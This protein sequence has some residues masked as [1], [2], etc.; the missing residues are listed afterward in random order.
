MARQVGGFGKM[1]RVWSRVYVFRPFPQKNLPRVWR[2][3]CVWRVYVFGISCL[4][5]MSHVFDVFD[6]FTCLGFFV[7]KKYGM[8]L[9]CLACLRVWEI[10]SSKIVACVWRVSGVGIFLVQIMSHVFDVIDVFGVFTCLDLSPKKWAMC[11]TCLR[12]W[13]FSLKILAM[14]LMCLRIWD[15]FSPKNEP[16]V[17]RVYVF[18]GT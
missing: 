4:Q 1:C 5:E 7:S 11:L 16:C 17:W 9:T 14:C 10:F 3:W 8:C 6:V 12:V 2:V 18:Q 15:F 13:D